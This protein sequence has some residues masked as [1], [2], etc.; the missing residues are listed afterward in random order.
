MWFVTTEPVRHPRQDVGGEAG[1][2]QD[3][4]YY[5]FAG[6]GFPG[7]DEA[8][9]PQGIF[10]YVPGRAR[11]SWC[12]TRRTGWCSLFLLG[13]EYPRLYTMM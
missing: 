11:S 2:L 13:G 8:R 6:S 12:L 5:V 4:A 3:G 10:R 7:P 1:V 9:V